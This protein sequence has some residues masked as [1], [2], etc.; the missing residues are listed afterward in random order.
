MERLKNIF[1]KIGSLIPGYS[2]YAE[3]EGR[4]NTDK[5]LREK[6]FQT[7]LDIERLMHTK[8]DDAL[9]RKD[10]SLAMEIDG[11]R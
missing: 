1:D 5:I 9:K 10:F 2:G 6:I 11:F 7:I 4:R 8:I 3:R